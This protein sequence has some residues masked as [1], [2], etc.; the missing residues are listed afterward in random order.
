[1]ARSKKIIVGNWKINPPT[2]HDAKRILTSLAERSA[3]VQTIIC[4]PYV[5]LDECARFLQSK[6]EKMK[7]KTPASIMLGVQNLSIEPL[8]PGTGEVSGELLK[9][10]GVSHVII[11][12]SE[13][14]ALGETDDIVN[15]KVIAALRWKFKPI[16]CIGEKTRDDDGEYLT[17]IKN[18]VQQALAGVPK[19][20]LSSVII[21]YEPVWAIGAAAA[22][23]PSAVHETVLFI[24]KTLFEMY[25]TKTMSV[26]ILYGG[27]VD[28]A[29]TRD[30][31]TTG[32]AGG[33]LVGRQSLDPEA[34]GTILTIAA[35][36]S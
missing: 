4:P 13:R 8:G 16:I 28:A 33:L 10:F 3:A 1:M 29:N 23:N 18:Q 27:S 21:A 34:F 6:K 7:K 30:I 5:Y 35:S 17:V 25:K 32:A 12:H 19:E 26:P 11:G 14:R 36:L 24:R 2:A 9:Q 20:S 31:L 22:M 15:K